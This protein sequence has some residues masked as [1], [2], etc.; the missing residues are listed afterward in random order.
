MFTKVDGFQNP[1]STPDTD[2]KVE[3]CDIFRTTYN[4]LQKNYDSIVKI[5]PDSAEPIKAH[6]NSIKEQMEKNRC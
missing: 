1:T 4:S 5:K 2:I 3:M 6:M